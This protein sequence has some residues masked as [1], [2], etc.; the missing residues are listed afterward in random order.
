MLY[1]SLFF[2]SAQGVADI[3][4]SNGVFNLCYSKAAAFRTAYRALKPGGR[5]YL[6][7]V[8]KQEAAQSGVAV[9]A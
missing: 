1:G 4:Y 2:L 8:M 6:C 7:D 3:V 5:L 9:R